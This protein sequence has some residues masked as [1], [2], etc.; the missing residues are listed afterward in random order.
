MNILRLLGYVGPTVLLVV[1]S[2]LV[3][4]WRLPSL[5]TLPVNDFDKVLYL[6][7]ALFDPYVASGILAA[8]L[9]S[10]AWL[11]AISKIPLNVGFPAY[12]GL[13][14][15]FV[16]LGSAWVLNEQITSLKL[17]GVGLILTGVIVG[18]LD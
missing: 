11:A 3:I 9:A 8:F 18:S 15:A 14:F 6:L 1:Y 17:I 13:T 2:Q 4:K 5:G 7:K 16:M 10:L 12:Y